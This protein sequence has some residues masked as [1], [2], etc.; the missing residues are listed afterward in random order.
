[1]AEFL[2]HEEISD[3][4]DLATVRRG[5]WAV[6]LPDPPATAPRLPR[7][8]MTGSQDSYERCRAEARRLRARGA[9]GLRAPS[10]ALLPRTP[11]GWVVRR[12]LQPGPRRVESVFV[13]YG[14]RP[15]LVGW[16]AC[17]AGRPRADLLPRVR[18]LG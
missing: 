10:A 9:T 18:R 13:L 14:P 16:A 12:G 5:L 1:W 4:D 15:D 8:A 6:E 17:A 11:S 3:P 2:R 7:A